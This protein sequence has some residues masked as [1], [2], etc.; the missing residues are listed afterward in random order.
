MNRVHTLKVPLKNGEVRCVPGRTLWLQ[1]PGTDRE[2]KFALTQSLTYGYDRKRWPALTHYG[3]GQRVGETYAHWA[4]TAGYVPPH[5][6]ARR[7]LQRIVAKYGVEET[8]RRMREAEPLNEA[9]AERKARR[10][11]AT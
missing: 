3:S 2:I 1:I 6:M 8:L 7:I 11:E 9:H 10:K 5:D 4:G